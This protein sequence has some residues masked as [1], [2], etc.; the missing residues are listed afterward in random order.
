MVYHYQVDNIYPVYLFF[1]IEEEIGSIKKA[2]LKHSG[3][4][5]E[6]SMKCVC[7]LFFS[8]CVLLA[9]AVFLRG[10]YAPAGQIILGPIFF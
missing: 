4:S 8:Q 6:R 2:N 9:D 7:I 1:L 5:F 3:S 10:V